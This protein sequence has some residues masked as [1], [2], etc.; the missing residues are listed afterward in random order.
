MELLSIIIPIYNVERTLDRCVESV[1]RQN[2]QPMEIILV[3]DGSPDACPQ[4]CDV[5]AEKDSRIHV[6]HKENGGLSDARNAGIAEAK[7]DLITFVDSDDFLSDDSYRQVLKEMTPDVDIIEFPVYRFYGSPHQSLLSFEEKT[8]SNRKDYWFN[9]KA[10]THT[11]AWNKIYRRHLFE[12]T[13]FPKGKVFED[14][15]TLP[16]L[17][18]Q[19]RKVKTTNKG[20]YFYCAN[21]KGI[22]AK[23]T[24]SDLQ[25]LLQVH[26]D[27]W[28]VTENDE[29]YLHVLNI[30]LDVCRLLGTQPILP[31]HKIKS[32][33]HYTWRMKM[34]ALAVNWIGLHHLCSI[35]R[36][37][38]PRKGKQ[39]ER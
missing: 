20:L 10:Y 1:L 8:Y 34:K 28:N 13:R 22:T 32:F 3:D 21:E 39:K 37:L 33:S 31:Y 25:V 30:Q 16:G 18:K 12:T 2:I 15:A 11:Y 26:L 29:Y 14:A 9:C 36:M 19:A 24:G 17:L 5:W 35:Y 23:A 6:V 27:H 7:G 38:S 4:L